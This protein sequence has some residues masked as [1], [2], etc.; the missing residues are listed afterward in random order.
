MELKKNPKVE[1]LMATY[2]G[3]NYIEE[4][5]ESLFN[6][7]YTNWNLLIRDDGSKDRTIEIVKKLE[8]QYPSKI[9]LLR[10]NKGGLRAKDNFLEL[11]RNSKENYIMFCDQDDIWLPNKIEL[12]LNKMLEIEDGP[13]L[14]HT[15]LKVVDKSL[16]IIA[17]SFWKFQNL[18]PN[19]KTYN[20]LIVQNNITGC[21][22]ML[23]RKLVNLSKGDFPNGTM[24]DWIISIIASISGKI[25][26]V[27]EQT[28][29]YRQHPFNQ[30]GAT[31]ISISYIKL[32]IK[33]LKEDS[34]RQ[35]SQVKDII[36]SLE[37]I[38]VK[39]RDEIEEFITIKTKNIWLQK[40]WIFRKKFL[41]NGILK[42]IIHWIYF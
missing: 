41:K 3:E 15:D 34:I 32:K 29:L 8:K 13:T 30:I 42:K 2:N 19:R 10:D 35:I 31:K 39:N 7:T 21:T 37:N 33:N 36:D 20:Y 17:N 9:K 5:I 38:E 14:I 24:H 26:Y 1:I 18:N 11:L 25:A 23:N 6:Q 12:T 22:M 27:S 4:Q 28:V 40:K 16:N